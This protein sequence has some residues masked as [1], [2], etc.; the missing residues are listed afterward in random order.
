MRRLSALQI[1][2][3]PPSAADGSVGITGPERRASNLIELWADQ[4][5]DVTIL[6]PR[7][8]SLWSRFADTGLPLFDYELRGKWDWRSIAQLVRIAGGCG[9][10]VIH[11]QGG[12]AVDLASVIAARLSGAR[13]IITRPSMIEDQVDRS[14]RELALFGVVDRRLTLPNAAA[15]VAVSRNGFDRLQ[16]RAPAN[17]VRLIFNGVGS[18]P[19][20][21]LTGRLERQSGPHQVGM[22]GHLLPY[23]GWLDF[24]AVAAQ[25][26]ASGV[27]VQWHVVGEGPDRG[28]LEARAAKLGLADRVIF[29]GLLKDVSAVLF[30][31]DL[32]LFTSHRE[33]L[34]VAVLE[35]MSAGLPIV[36]TDVAGIRDQVIDGENGYIAPV[37][38]IEALTGHVIAILRDAEQR[39]R[40]GSVSRYRAERLF[41]QQAM[42]DGYVSLYRDVVGHKGDS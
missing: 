10:D 20:E 33:G 28:M 40:L 41:S 18:F 11:A 9:V 29:H 1:V 34:S 5:I 13:T 22:V 19:A 42:L 12:P 21:R 17:K 7:R 14:A 26:M 23:K 30:E 37:Q 4:G 38:D 27:D 25:V 6:Y 31:L 35:A 8:G 39:R 16:E 24:L 3:P 36:A 32:F 15:L 2:S